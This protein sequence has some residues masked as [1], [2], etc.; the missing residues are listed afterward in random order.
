MGTGGDTHPR[1]DGAQQADTAYRKLTVVDGDDFYGERAML[2]RNW[3]AN[4]ENSGPSQTNGAFALGREGGTTRSLFG[5]CAS[6]QDFRWPRTPGNKIPNGS[7]P[8]PTPML[9]LPPVTRMETA[10]HSRCSCMA[11]SS[12]FRPGGSRGG[13][14]RRLRRTAGFGSPPMSPSRSGQGWARLR[15]LSTATLTA[16]FSTSVKTP[17]C[18]AWSH[19]QCTTTADNGLAAGGSIPA[20]LALGV[21]HNPSAFGTTSVELDNIQVSSG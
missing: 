11:I 19:T 5:R 6:R 13:P 3:W 9:T 17:T 15:S 16:T 7:R 2:G 21:Y 20:M 12:G 1:G 4:G 8:S 18:V 14:L 10:S